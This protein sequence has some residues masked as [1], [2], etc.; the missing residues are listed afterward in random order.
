[1]VVGIGLRSGGTPLTGPDDAQMTM[2]Q[3][4]AAIGTLLSGD[5][6]AGRAQLLALWER[7]PGDA[8]RCVLAHYIADTEDDAAA[9]LRWDREALRAADAAMQHG[10]Q[11]LMPGLT[12]SAFYPSLYLNVAD[13]SLR[14]GELAP[15]RD[16]FEA[17]MRSLSALPDTP[18]SA[19]VRDGMARLGRRIADAEAAPRG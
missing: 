17:G 5:R 13:A 6:A 3:A 19:T 14:N 11:A 10:D 8:L 4:L 9:E 15:A 2:D 7:A 12:V 18:Y 1:M 16:Y